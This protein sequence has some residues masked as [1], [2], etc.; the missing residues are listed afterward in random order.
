[1]SEKAVRMHR[2]SIIAVALSA[3]ASVAN[4]QSPPHRGDPQAGRQLASHACDTCHI[5]T[6][7]QEIRPLVRGYAPSFL[8]IAN[9]PDVTAQSL[10][11]FLAHRHPYPKMPPPELTAAQIRDLVSY[12]LSLRGGH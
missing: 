10:E 6:A 7:N 5:V 2:N 4:A 3:T 9:K 12:I 8:D 11:D 1:M